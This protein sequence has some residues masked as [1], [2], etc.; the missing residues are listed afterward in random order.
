M[1]SALRASSVTTHAQP[2]KAVVMSSLSVR[3]APSCDSRASIGLP[4][5]VAHV[6]RQEGD[7]SSHVVVNADPLEPKWV[8]GTAGFEAGVRRDRRPITGGSRGCCDGS[9]VVTIRIAE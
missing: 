6:E 8:R 4:D 7:R 1:A 3:R 5:L 2:R 9:R